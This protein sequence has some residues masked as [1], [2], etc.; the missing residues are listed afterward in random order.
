[1][2]KREQIQ[3]FEDRKV[4]TVWDEEHKEIKGLTKKSH[5]SSWFL[6]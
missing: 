6:S 2:T 1:M 5:R 4:R 3:L